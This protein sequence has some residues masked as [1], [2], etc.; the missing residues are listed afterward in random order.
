L[1]GF[2]EGARG[3]FIKVIGNFMENPEYIYHYTSVETLALILKYRKIRFNSISNV[4]DLSE[5]N[6]D[7][8]GQIGSLLLLSCWTSEKDENIAFWNMYGKKGSGVRIKMRPTLFSTD[9]FEKSDNYRSPSSNM[10]ILWPINFL[11]PVR[12]TEQVK[13]TVI[14]FEDK[15]FDIAELGKFKEKIWAFQNEWRFIIYQFPGKNSIKHIIDLKTI[16]GLSF[17]F[18]H[19][20]MCIKDEEFYNMEILLGPSTSESEKIIVE[21]LL[22]IYNPNAKLKISALK[23]KVK[24]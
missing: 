9:I 11:F 16:D 6:A 7:D 21:S 18:K 20:D 2:F 10:D 13:R 1:R 3:T 8:I 22:N 15:G 14:G 5:S 4:D 17:K 24:L 12:Y 23:D 19:Y